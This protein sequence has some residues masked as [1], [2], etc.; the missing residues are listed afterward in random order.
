VST[1]TLHDRADAC[2]GQPNRAGN[3]ADRRAGTVRVHVDDPANELGAS[4]VGALFTDA[5][6]ARSGLE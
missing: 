3:L 4:L 6:F 2:S 5:D 1:T